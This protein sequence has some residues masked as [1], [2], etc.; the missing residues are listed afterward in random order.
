MG[1]TVAHWRPSSLAGDESGGKASKRESDMTNATAPP[2]RGMGP[3]Q[4]G[5]RA[6]MSAWHWVY[7][8]SDK[9]AYANAVLHPAPGL[10]KPA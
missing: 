7:T 9:V 10:V 4:L 2:A 3:M 6:A 1:V 8:V 5:D